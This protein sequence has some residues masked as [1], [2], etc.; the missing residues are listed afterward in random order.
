MQEKM[1]R[2]RKTKNRPEGWPWPCIHYDDDISQSQVTC[3]TGLGQTPTV[4]FLGNGTVY[5]KTAQFQGS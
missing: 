1:W 5:S 3:T 4:Y 2:Q